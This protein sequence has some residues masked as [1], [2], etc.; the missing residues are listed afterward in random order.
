MGQRK[1]HTL[2]ASPGL[3]KL[4]VEAG[5]PRSGGAMERRKCLMEWTTSNLGKLPSHS[6][7]DYSHSSFNQSTTGKG[8]PKL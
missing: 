5:A 6:D 8:L 7:T 1:R 3:L 2:S 4:F